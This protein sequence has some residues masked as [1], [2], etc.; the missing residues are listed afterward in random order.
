[1]RTSIKP[2]PYARSKLAHRTLGE[3]GA[4]PVRQ[5]R[6][7]INLVQLVF[8]ISWWTAFAERNQRSRQIAYQ[9]RRDS[10]ESI[11][12]KLAFL[13]GWW[14]AFAERNQRSRQI[15][16][17]SRRDGWGVA[18]EEVLGRDNNLEQSRRDGWKSIL[19]KLDFLISWWTAFAERNQRSR[20]I[21]K[22]S[23]RDGWE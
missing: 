6:L 18:Q 17:Q 15:A 12:S 10:W 4:D 2:A 21:A 16:K 20:Q 13:I 7:G 9:S 22:Q 3:L 5:R 14:T 19:S 1:M 23:R 11:L 8:L